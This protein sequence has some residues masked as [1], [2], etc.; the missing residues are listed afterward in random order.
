M[1]LFNHF[2]MQFTQ[3]F[4]VYRFGLC[5]TFFSLLSIDP[6]P[7]SFT[8]KYPRNFY[9]TFPSW[10]PVNM[11]KSPNYHGCKYIIVLFNMWSAYS[12]ETPLQIA[13]KPIF[14]TSVLLYD[15]VFW[16]IYYYL[17]RFFY[18]YRSVS[19]ISY[20]LPYPMHSIPTVSCIEEIIWIK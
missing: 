10:G 13:A 18:L 5:K 19:K 17:Y 2:C 15:S 16:K 14:A 6:S 1:F 20:N 11:I 4:S 9:K 8:L 3:L 7:E 12:Q